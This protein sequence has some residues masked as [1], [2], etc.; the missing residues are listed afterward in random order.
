[1]SSMLAAAGREGQSPLDAF[2]SKKRPAPTSAEAS[3]SKKPR[4]KREAGEAIIV[5]PRKPRGRANIVRSDS[6]E[7]QEAEDEADETG[8]AGNEPE[9]L[10]SIAV[11]PHRPFSFLSTHSS[12][13]FFQTL[14]AEAAK[15]S[16]GKAVET[17]A[18]PRRSGRARQPVTSK[19]TPAAAASKRAKALA[20]AAPAAAPAA[21]TSTPAPR[22]VSPAASVASRRGGPGPGKPS[23]GV[24][25]V[26]RH[27]KDTNLPAVGS[28]DT[29]SGRTGASSFARATFAPTGAPVLP[30]QGL[31]PLEEYE[32]SN[33]G[34]PSTSI[35][36]FSSL[37]LY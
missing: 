31:L 33:A 17:P 29:L 7:Y 9:D 21:S 22:A 11:S 1:M 28:A 34:H 26:H 5:V 15:P 35:P 8:D 30:L 6:E 3:T 10:P 23:G 12:F 14:S 18:G 16:K 36:S 37:Q 24:P 2:L 19:S 25:A 32:T 27:H 4:V 13:F 20:S